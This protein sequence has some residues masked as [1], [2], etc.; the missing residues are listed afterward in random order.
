M[1]AAEEPAWLPRKTKP[2]IPDLIRHPLGAPHRFPIHTDPNGLEI[3]GMTKP[4]G[5]QAPEW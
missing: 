5:Y 4:T 2:V 3:S 1:T